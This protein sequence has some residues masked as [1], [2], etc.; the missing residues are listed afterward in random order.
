MSSS[1]GSEATRAPSAG[2]MEERKRKRKE[3]NRLSAQRSRARKLLQVDELEAEAAALGAKNSAVAAKARE[4]A[5]R[6]AVVQAENELLH[7]RALE[8]GARLESLAEFIQYMDAAADSGASSSPFAG[9]SGTALLQQ[10]LLQ[11][12]LYCN[13]NYTYY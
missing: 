7:A 13:C 4:A 9:V 3:S 11:T 8:L 12:D 2:L 5:R 6:C 1:A 10:P